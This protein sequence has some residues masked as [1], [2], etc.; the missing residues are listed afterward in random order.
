M[1]YADML[2]G[3]GQQGGYGA[4]GLMQPAGDVVPFRNPLGQ[5]ANQFNNPETMAKLRALAAQSGMSLEQ[6]KYIIAQ[7]MQ[8]R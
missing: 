6:L 1:N 3:M 7:Q 4:Q 2:K 5:A 8:S